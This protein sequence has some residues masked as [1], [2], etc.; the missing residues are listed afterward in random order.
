MDG[1]LPR[2]VTLRAAVGALLC[3]MGLV[4][5][6]ADVRAQAPTAPAASQP[7]AQSVLP[8]QQAPATVMVWNRALAVFR[9][10]LR[11]T[12][13]RH[14]AD[15]ATARLE[16]A[17][18]QLSPDEIRYSV[19][20]VGADRGAI[21]LGGAEALFAILDGDLPQDT[22]TTLDAAGAQAVSRLQTV[23][24]ERSEQRRW[25]V[26]LRSII[27]AC[28]PRRHSLPSGAIGAPLSSQ[29]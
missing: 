12:T 22:A 11:S 1:P 23:L 27:E 18:T 13:P 14:R 25:P 10:S 15:A 26:L 16:P 21:V 19:V 8:S 5:V 6:T 29:L 7:S 9:T 4:A 2:G 17:I 20:Q 28:S 24:R 3:C